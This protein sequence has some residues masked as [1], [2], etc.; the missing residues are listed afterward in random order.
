M[1]N[2]E[3]KEYLIAHCYPDYPAEGKIQWDKA[4]HKAIEALDKIEELSDTQKEVV[5]KLHQYKCYISDQEGLQHEVIHID[6]IYRLIS[7]HSNYHG[8]NILTALTCLAEG[9]EVL[10]PITVLD[11]QPER[12][13]GR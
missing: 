1:T 11:T 13:R 6:D 2:K 4:M 9:K 3:A 10:K 8:D 5:E 12:L 7:G